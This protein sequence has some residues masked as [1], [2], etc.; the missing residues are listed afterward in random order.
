LSDHN[1]NIQGFCKADHLR[2]LETGISAYAKAKGLQSM[3]DSTS[4]EEIEMAY[5]VFGNRRNFATLKMASTW[6]AQ[7]AATFTKSQRKTLRRQKTGVQQQGL[8]AGN[9]SASDAKV[10]AEA[11]DVMLSY[12]FKKNTGESAIVESLLVP[13]ESESVD[14]EK[15]NSEATLNFI[16]IASWM[17]DMPVSQ[18]QGCH[19]A[20]LNLA[21]DMIYRDEVYIQVM[22]QLTGNTR[23]FS[24]KAGW[25]LLHHLLAS[26]PPSP[27]MGEFLRAFATDALD[28]LSENPETA[29]WGTNVATIALDSLKG[30][31][32]W[33]RVDDRWEA[34]TESVWWFKVESPA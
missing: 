29:E 15:F 11:F 30:K 18:R 27:T 7:G 34:V 21:A 23:P 8:F 14:A 24:L 28:E 1:R 9:P 26:A 5:N 10:Q 32:K 3:F 12:S 17:G 25:I 20:I 19:D 4:P 31:S 33:R 2:A 13:P 6:G 16:N 22:K